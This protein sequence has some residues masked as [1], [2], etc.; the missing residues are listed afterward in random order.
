MKKHTK[1][2]FV[3]IVAVTMLTTAA[4]MFAGNDKQEA[5]NTNIAS[6][7]LHNYNWTEE[8]IS[9]DINLKTDLYVNCSKV[10]FFDVKDNLINSEVVNCTNKRFALNFDTFYQGDNVVTVYYGD[11]GGEYNRKK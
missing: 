2:I 10:Y 5:K 8:N 4:F 1:I 9:I 6:F 3:V 7:T 11:Y